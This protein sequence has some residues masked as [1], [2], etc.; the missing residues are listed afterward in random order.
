MLR[1]TLLLCGLSAAAAPRTWAQDAEPTPEADEIVVRGAQVSLIAEVDIPARRTGVIQN[2]NVKAGETVEPGQSLAKLDDTEARLTVAEAN[3]E[4]EKAHELAENDVEI[5]AARKARDVAQAELQRAL[6]A[7][8]RYSKAIS[9]T[10][11]DRLRLMLD[12]AE[13]AI[14]QAELAKRTAGFDSKLRQTKLDQARLDVDHHVIRSSVGG[15]VVKLNHQPGE[16]VE[17]GTTI[18]E[19]LR[20]DRLQCEGRIHRELSS[21]AL[22]GRPVKIDVE[23][24]KEKTVTL[25]GVVTFVDPRVN[26]VKEDVVVWAE[27]D[28]PKLQIS[29]GMRAT[30][31]IQPAG[32]PA[33]LA[34]Q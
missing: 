8:E 3:I 33:K 10:E 16:W 15:I 23:L 18:M 14:Q 28:N 29:P 31:R 21:T 26:P 30:I 34:A 19:L 1:F 20:L 12:R 4:L 17:K 9:R 7:V 5:T 13:L 2:V 24:S 11:I 25:D 32:T 6:E 27:F 22:I